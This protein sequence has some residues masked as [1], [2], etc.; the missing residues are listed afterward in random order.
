LHVYPGA[1]HGFT[2]IAP[3]AAVTQQCLG[4]MEAW[5]LRQFGQR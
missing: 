3:G 5:L 1:C 4:N 2:M